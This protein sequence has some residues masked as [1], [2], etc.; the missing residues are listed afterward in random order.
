VPDAVVGCRPGIIL[1]P[2]RDDDGK[3][4]LAGEPPIAQNENADIA[5]RARREGSER[6]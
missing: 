5:R 4:P 1:D 6:T 2:V 3:T